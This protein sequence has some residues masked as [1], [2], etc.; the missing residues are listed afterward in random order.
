M[1][2]SEFQQ[3]VIEMAQVLGWRVVHFRPART[4]T[5]WRTPVEGDGAGWPDLILV[6]D[7]IV[8]LE[9]KTATGKVT[10]EQAAWIAAINAAGGM[11]L[12]VRPKDMPEIERALRRR[13]P[14]S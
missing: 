7:R 14:A 9:L 8:F 11:A 1:R 6:R 5:G 3:T 4:T 12:A 10:A 13:R 2:E